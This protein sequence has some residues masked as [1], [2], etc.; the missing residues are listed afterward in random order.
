MAIL[1]GIKSI[2]LL[3]RCMPKDWV[4]TP[5]HKKEKPKI[6]KKHHIDKLRKKEAER[7]LLRDSLVHFTGVDKW[8]SEEKD[9]YLQAVK[10]VNE[11]LE[12]C[13]QNMIE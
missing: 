2:Q 6:H 8:S 9:L 11:A 13:M 12:P 1:L 7:F 3:G 5:K 4:S 10:A